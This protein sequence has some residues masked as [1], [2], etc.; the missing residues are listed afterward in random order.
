[1]A[2][3]PLTVARRPLKLLLLGVVVLLYAAPTQIVAM[4]FGVLGGGYWMLH[5]LEHAGERRQAVARVR[6]TS[7]YEQV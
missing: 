7:F 5:R 1:M 3:C 2:R 6:L 4:V